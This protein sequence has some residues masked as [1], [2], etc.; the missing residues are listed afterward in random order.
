MAAPAPPKCPEKDSDMN[1]LP[2]VLGAKAGKQEPFDTIIHIAGTDTSASIGRVADAGH[3]IDNLIYRG[4]P[5]GKRSYAEFARDLTLLC[6]NSDLKGNRRNYDTV[7]KINTVIESFVGDKSAR[8]EVILSTIEF[9][10]FKA[11]SA[12]IYERAIFN[13]LTNENGGLLGNID[14]IIQDSSPFSVFVSEDGTPLIGAGRSVGKELQF[15]EH[16]VTKFDGATKPSEKSIGRHMKYVEIPG[17]FTVHEFIPGYRHT[18]SMA[19]AMVR[20]Q[21]IRVRDA[22]VICTITCAAGVSVNALCEAV[23]LL[24]PRGKGKVKHKVTVEWAAGLTD[25]DIEPVLVLYIKTITDWAQFYLCAMLWYKYGIKVAI[26]SFDRFAVRLAR[27]L[28]TPIIIFVSPLG[29]AN[30]IINDINILNLSVD[31]KKAILIKFV[32]FKMLGDTG[33]LILNTMKNTV[34]RE[35]KNIPFLKTRSN[36]YCY[37]ME[38]ELGRIL[39]DVEDIYGDLLVDIAKIPPIPDIE[40]FNVDTIDTKIYQKYFAL[41]GKTVQQYMVDL[42]RP[43][44]ELV[45]KYKSV[46]YA[47]ISAITNWKEHADRILGKNIVS[48]DVE[49]AKEYVSRIIRNLYSLTPSTDADAAKYVGAALSYLPFSGGAS[50]K[51]LDTRIVL[52]H[53]QINDD[54]VK[55]RFLEYCNVHYRLSSTG[56]PSV[57]FARLMGVG[58]PDALET[59]DVEYTLFRVRNP[60]IAAAA[61]PILIN[62]QNVN[63]SSLGKITDKRMP[64]DDMPSLQYFKVLE[65]RL[66]SILQLVQVIADQ[67]VD[68]IQDITDE[69]EEEEG[70]SSENAAGAAA[71]AGGAAAAGSS[72]SLRHELFLSEEEEEEEAAAAAAAAAPAPLDTAAAAAAAAAA[73]PAPLDTAAAAAAALKSVVLE[74]INKTITDATTQAPAGGA[75]AAAAAASAVKPESF[76]NS[77]IMEKIKKAYDAICKKHVVDSL[78]DV[79]KGTD[80]FTDVEDPYP[81]T[82]ST[83]FLGLPLAT[84]GAVANATTGAIGW[85][86]SMFGGIFS[87]TR[88]R[89]STAPTG[90]ILQVGG[91]Y[92]E[93]TTEY[94]FMFDLNTPVIHIKDGK[95]KTL[96]TVVMERMNRIFNDT[97]RGT[98]PYG[99]DPDRYKGYNLSSIDS[100][101][102][103]IKCMMEGLVTAS[104]ARG[105]GAAAAAAPATTVLPSILDDLS[106]DA[107]NNGLDTYYFAAMENLNILYMHNQ[108][109]LLSSHEFLKQLACYMFFSNEIS[110]IFYREFAWRDE[111]RDICLQFLYWIQNP[112]LSVADPSVVRAKV[113]PATQAAA[114]AAAGGAP[115]G[116]DGAPGRGGAGANIEQGGGA[117]T[118]FHQEGGSGRGSSRGAAAAAATTTDRTNEYKLRAQITTITLKLNEL[119]RALIAEKAAPAARLTDAEAAA[120]AAAPRGAGAAAAPPGMDEEIEAAAPRGAAAA[121]ARSAGGIEDQIARLKV[122]RGELSKALTKLHTENEKVAEAAA[123]AVA[124]VKITATEDPMAAAAA[125]GYSSLE[126]QIKDIEARKLTAI[127]ANEIAANGEVDAALAAVSVGLG[128]DQA[129]DLAAI[130]LGAEEER[131]KLAEAALE[132]AHVASETALVEVS[133]FGVEFTSGKKIVR[134]RIAAAIAGVNR[135]ALAA[136][137]KAKAN[138]DAEDTAV[139]ALAAREKAARSAD[140]E[141]EEEAA[142]A[143]GGAGAASTAAVREAAAGRPPAA[144]MAAAPRTAAGGAGAASAAGGVSADLGVRGAAAA[145]AAG[146]VAAPPAAAGGAGAVIGVGSKRPALKSESG[147]FSSKAKAG[148]GGG[149]GDKDG[150]PVRIPSSGSAGASSSSNGDDGDRNHNLNHLNVIYDEIIAADTAEEGAVGGGTLGGIEGVRRYLQELEDSDARRSRRES[151]TIRRKNAEK[152]LEIAK[153]W[154]SRSDGGGS[155]LPPGVFSSGGGG[156]DGGGA[157]AGAGPAKPVSLQRM[158]LAGKNGGRPAHVHNITPPFRQA[159][160]EALTGLGGSPDDGAGGGGSAAAASGGGGGGGSSSSL[161]PGFF[162]SGGDSNISPP[163][164]FASRLAAAAAAAAAGSS[165]APAPAAAGGPGMQLEKKGNNLGGGARRT[166]RR[167]NH[168]RKRNRTRRRSAR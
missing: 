65:A 94:C 80:N 145:V 17:N 62:G 135:D 105:A 160:I 95:F 131:R 10:D 96:L 27:W 28:G 20:I 42:I 109:G 76:F 139:A 92:E 136:Y 79:V 35:L 87:F 141:L 31:D 14:G 59:T 68:A 43:I 52:F 89:G 165:P 159:F 29:F 146:M 130:I 100:L 74:E 148:E 45:D 44:T 91:D 38:K 84:L 126:E 143:A 161:P 121:A 71:V 73:A 140:M 129:R 125:A 4:F 58:A 116:G 104:A 75:G 120:A 51:P 6:N 72:Q 137:E 154:R 12:G 25:D 23:G 157:G 56:T 8:D 101:D 2:P 111:I 55:A 24:P 114:A 64:N 119:E 16:I 98:P 57:S 156:G 118:L 61:P 63:D 138:R 36:L 108:D 78:D 21:I 134:G 123:K 33:T 30:I 37:L 142:A 110:E 163:N 90:P 103:F 39:G 166:R 150:P 18:Y 11:S 102:R 151:K 22:K 19:G 34:D 122:L 117:R 132:K 60:V 127:Q 41:K 93:K 77:S 70:E 9:N 168:Y 81:K 5:G 49:N 147:S 158:G 82:V 153:R 83:S 144:A 53:S 13:T 7:D 67:G 15:F 155:S 97:G 99:V 112:T 48:G 115:G 167:A 85:L 107:T 164:L 124:A 149:D 162:S 47:N 3:D 106:I 66:M 50:Q 128:S 54:T 46:H 133:R 88:S 32:N 69:E 26:V 86:G 40:T 152:L 113:S 1:P